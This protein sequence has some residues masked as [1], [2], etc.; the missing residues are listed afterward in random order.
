MRK[1]VEKPRVG[2]RQR[3]CKDECDHCRDLEKPCVRPRG[4]ELALLD[5][6]GIVKDMKALGNAW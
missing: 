4:G 6:P 3:T 2:N 5:M 1:A